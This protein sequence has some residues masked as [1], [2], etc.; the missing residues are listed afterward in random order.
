M[1]ICLQDGVEIARFKTYD[2]ALAYMV[3][4]FGEYWYMRDLGIISG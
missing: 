1:Y 4:R 3:S 2:K